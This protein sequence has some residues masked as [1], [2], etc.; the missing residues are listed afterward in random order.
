MKKIAIIVPAYNE[1]K[2]IAGVVNEINTIIIGDGFIKDVVVVNDCSLDQTA[3]IVSNLKCTLIDLPVNIGIGGAVQT[4]FKYAYENNYDFAMQVDGDGQHP[5]AEIPKL[6]TAIIQKEFDV[7]IGSRF[8]NKTGFLST[9]SRRL[10]ITF[11]KYLIRFLCGITITDSTS[12]FRIISRKT[13][14][15]VNDYY[16]EEYPEPESIILYK[17]HNLQIGEMPVKMLKRQGGMS[18]IRAFTSLYYMMKV[19]MAIVFTYIRL[20]KLKY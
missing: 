12:G 14:E 18:S 6:I 3:N 2:N 7:I 19:S 9:F 17:K 8:I 5:P 1:E 16:P 13:L 15:I 4:G 11:F 10:G 20:R